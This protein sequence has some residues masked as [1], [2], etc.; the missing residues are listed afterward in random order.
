MK[1][2]ILRYW[3]LNN[4]NTYDYADESLPII[5]GRDENRFKQ[6][7]F[8]SMGEGKGEG[9]RGFGGSILLTILFMLVISLIFCITCS[10]EKTKGKVDLNVIESVAKISAMFDINEEKAVKMLEEAKITAEEYKDIITEIALDAKATGVFIE[11]KISY[12]KQF[13]K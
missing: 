5:D 12:K 4:S 1:K 10:Q 11:K 3:N 2:S 6:I 13:Q 9:V 8:P 7:P